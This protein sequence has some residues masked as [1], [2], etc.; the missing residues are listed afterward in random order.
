[1]MDPAAR[2]YMEQVEGVVRPDA[3]LGR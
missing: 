2:A 1:V 3:R